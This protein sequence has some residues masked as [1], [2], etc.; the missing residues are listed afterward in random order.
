MSCEGERSGMVF[1]HPSFSGSFF[2][3]F[4]SPA[5]LDERIML[6]RGRMKKESSRSFYDAEGRVER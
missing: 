5:L 6:K 3:G 1:G 2:K 4:A